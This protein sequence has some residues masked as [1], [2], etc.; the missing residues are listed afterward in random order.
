MDKFKSGVSDK[1]EELVLLMLNA[2]V[3]KLLQY[4]SMSLMPGN[5][6]VKARPST[7]ELLADPVVMTKLQCVT[8]LRK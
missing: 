7:V 6:K 1:M 8:F 4:F 5:R 3:R 2:K